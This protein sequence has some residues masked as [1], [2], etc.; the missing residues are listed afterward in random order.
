MSHGIMRRLPMPTSQRWILLMAA[1]LTLFMLLSNPALAH[2]VAHGDRMYRQQAQGVLTLPFLYL[3][4]KHM[5][6]CCFC[7]G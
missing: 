7:L 2:G 1:T 3:G 4:A 5:V 6:T